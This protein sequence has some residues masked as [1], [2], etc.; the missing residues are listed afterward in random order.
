MTHKD[1]FMEVLAHLASPVCDD[2][3]ARL[4]LLPQRQ[5]AYQIGEAQ[6]NMGL[7]R[8][9]PTVCSQC[10]KVKKSTSLTDAD[11]RE[12]GDVVSPEQFEDFARPR[13]EEFFCTTL[14]KGSVAGV[15]KVWD[16]KSQD[17]SVVGA[18]K[19]YTIANSRDILPAKFAHIAEHIWLQSHTTATQR[20]LV[21]GGIRQ[22]PQQWLERYGSLADGI[23]FL[24][25]SDDGRL[26]RLN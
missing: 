20:F 5:L 4:A 11:A 22:V 14:P 7:V 13:L 2:C 6:K 23:I 3:M 21:F 16:Y 12:H 24:F 25:L 8:R 26:E 10:G 15:P 1:R 19:M 18:A 9:E 17:N